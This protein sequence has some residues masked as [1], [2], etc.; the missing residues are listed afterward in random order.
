ML[1]QL[2][3]IADPGR[4][5]KFEENKSQ[6]PA[7]YHYGASI[8]GGSFFVQP[9]V[10]TFL[11]FDQAQIDQ[12]HEKSHGA[13]DGGEWPT[14]MVDGVR[15]ETRFIGA[16]H[17]ATAVPIDQNSDYSNYFIGTDTRSWAPGV[18]NYQA[19]QYQAL[20]TGIDLMIYSSEQNLKYDFVVAAGADPSVIQFAYEGID[21][22]MLSAGGDLEVESQWPLFIEKKP[23]AYQYIDGR[24]VLVPCQYQLANGVVSFQFPKGYDACQPLV[25]DPL[26][27]FS[28]Y[29]GSTADNW[30]STATPGEHGTLYSAG[31]TWNNDGGR[32]PATTG[33]FQSVLSGAFDIGIL[34][35]DSTG[36]RLLYATYLGGTETDSPHS[37][38]VNKDNELL[39]LGT[40]SSMDYPTT[41]SAYDRVFAGGT[42]ANGVVSYRHGSDILISKFS[43]DGMNLLASTL[44]GGAENDGLNQGVLVQNYGDQQRG[45]II[46]DS[47]NNVYIATVTGSP[48]F[49]IV[50]GLFDTYGGGITDAVIIK[51]NPDL[52]SIAWST[53]VGGSGTDACHT[54]KFDKAG[55]LFIG[56]GT[57]SPEFPVTVGS[58]QTTF[59]GVADGWIASLSADGTAWQQATFTGTN[60]FDE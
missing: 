16:N 26:L 14:E 58:Y 41:P 49:P 11:F 30:G 21:K 36:T 7:T 15:V 45:D 38:V 40:T 1:I 32:F 24:R 4:G 53:F 19:V 55:D 6:W 9:G 39:V 25:I 13:D 17:R 12:W 28:T 46:T 43:S 54:I 51:M 22:V 42:P 5:L 57:S 8:P 2:V 23:V 50:N 52:T 31:V 47:S 10:F 18:R 3:S 44:L 20:Y 48:A 56:G 34:K 35:Y 60:S 33:A 27:I 29:S 59:K 37:L